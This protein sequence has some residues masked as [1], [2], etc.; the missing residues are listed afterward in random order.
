MRN[1]GYRGL[2]DTSLVNDTRGIHTARDQF[3]LTKRF[4]GAWFVDTEQIYGDVTKS[5]GTGCTSVSTDAVGGNFYFTTNNTADLAWSTRLK[6]GKFYFEIQLNSTGYLMITVGASTT[7]G[8]YAT[9]GAVWHYQQNGNL[10]VGNISTGLGGFSTT[11]EL[12]R[13]AYD[14]DNGKFWFGAND[15]WSSQTGDPGSGGSGI[16]ILGWSAGASGG[17][18]R[19]IF[20]VGS[21]AATSYDMEFLTGT[22]ITQ[23]VPTG[24]TAH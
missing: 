21:S 13:I 17:D 3:E 7:T 2:F 8:N 16:T 20:N 15:L 24:F 1:G 22:D 10:Y 11:N 19:T 9:N 12:L 23:S 14:T 18:Y 6:N 4:S 5:E